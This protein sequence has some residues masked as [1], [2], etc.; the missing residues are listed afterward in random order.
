MQ[1]RTRRVISRFGDAI[2]LRSPEWIARHY[3][4]IARR[5]AQPLMCIPEEMSAYNQL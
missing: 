4:D 2:W 3:N 1:E 5:V